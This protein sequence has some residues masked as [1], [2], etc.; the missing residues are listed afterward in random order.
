MCAIISPPDHISSSYETGYSPK[1]LMAAPTILRILGN[2]VVNGLISLVIVT[3]GI[4]ISIPKFLLYSASMGDSN[5]SSDSNSK[6]Y[7]WYSP[8]SYLSDKAHASMWEDLQ[9]KRTT[10]VETVCI[11]IS[12]SLLVTL[13]I[14][15]CSKSPIHF[16]NF[17]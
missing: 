3:F 16:L 1:I 4:M 2:P 15:S 7:C 13:F 8:L 12:C 5:E 14:F 9:R 10:E 11:S 17:Y 6:R